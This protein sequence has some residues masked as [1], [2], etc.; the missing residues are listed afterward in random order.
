MQKHKTSIVARALAA[1]TA[2]IACISMAACGSDDS[3]QPNSAI[4]GVSA[5]QIAGVTASGKPGE[6][7]TISFKTPLTVENNAY[8]ILEEGNG[9]QIKA[10]NRLCLQGLVI[11]TKDGTELNST[12]AS[13]QLDCS[14]ALNDTYRQSNPD[15]YE[16]FTHMKVNGTVAFGSND[17]TGAASYLFVYT[18]VDQMKDL[19]KAEG[20]KVKDIPAD[21]PTVTTAEDGKPSIDM[22]GYKGS[23]KLISQTIIE[24]TGPE[25]KEGD[26]AVVKY[27]G[28]LL[29]G[30]Q[31]DSSWD[32]NTTFDAPL[33]TSSTGGVIKG[34]EKGLQNHKVG[35][36]V[37]LVVP[38]DMGY[39]DKENGSIPANSTLVFVV[40]I[41]GKYK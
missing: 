2:L 1:A 7:P 5:K 3:A 39:G 26:Y 41:L 27:T 35:S 10:G 18:I 33:F 30:K 24:G 37:L 34:W 38:P 22:H 40:D 36:Q 4:P 32:K 8:V 23:D 11:N 17:G 20:T 14:V 31:F 25:T 15:R 19:T 21:L 13:G 29:N 9:A 28:W 6:K 16:I 12:W